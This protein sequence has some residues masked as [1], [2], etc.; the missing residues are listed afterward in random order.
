MMDYDEKSDMFFAIVILLLVIAYFFIPACTTTTIEEPLNCEMIDE[1][2]WCC[3]QED[4][5][6]TCE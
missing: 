6:W 5:R 4:G 3:Q 2:H 1:K